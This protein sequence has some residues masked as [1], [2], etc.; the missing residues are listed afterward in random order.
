[1][2]QRVQ[3]FLKQCAVIAEMATCP[4]AHHGAMIVDPYHFTVATGYNGSLPGEPHC[5][6]VGCDLHF[7]EGKPCSY[8]G[9]SKIVPPRYGEPH[10]DYSPP[11][12][13]CNGTG[14]RSHCMR[15]MHAE[16]N[17]L[18]QAAFRGASVSGCTM[19]VTGTPCDECQKHMRAAGIRT[20]VW[21]G[22]LI[23]WG[24]RPDPYPIGAYL[25]ER[26]A[27]DG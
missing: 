15:V 6:D 13:Y 8:C 23:D 27:R 26:T 1:M 5:E 25:A 14:T 7:I 24:E 3:N 4:R 19:Y 12:P 21:P 17:A 20:V 10:P 16:R 11:C 18:M 22:G 2:D 9:G